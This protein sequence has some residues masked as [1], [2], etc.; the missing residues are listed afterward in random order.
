MSTEVRIMSETGGQKGQKIERFDLI[1]IKPLTGLARVYG[2]GAAKYADD[3]YRKGYAWRLSFGAMLR[4]INLW[5]AGQSYDE[6]TGEHHLLHAAWHCFTLFIF[7]TEKLG[8]D[9][10][11]ERAGASRFGPPSI[12]RNSAE[13]LAEQFAEP[14]LY[15][16]H[17]DGSVT[18]Q[19]LPNL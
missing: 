12:A 17:A 9:D 5:A 2:K 18:V 15:T 4:H 3:N 10:I 8:T 1:P 13:P 16:V 11:P 19:K 14:G 7:E 6:E